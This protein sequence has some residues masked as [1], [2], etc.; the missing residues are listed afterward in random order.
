M[1]PNM[2]T[3][4]CF[5]FTSGCCKMDCN[6]GIKPCSMAITANF[7]ERLTIVP[8]AQQAASFNYIYI[9]VKKI[10]KIFFES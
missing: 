3:A 10:E 1:S 2:S 4:N 6:R 5:K 8:I 9:C 7:G